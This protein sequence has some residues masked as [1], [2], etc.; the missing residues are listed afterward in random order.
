MR[1]NQFEM[2]AAL[3][4][5][6]SL[7]EASEKL[8]ISQ[9]SI[10]KAIRELEDEVGY[11]IIKRTKN[12]VEFTEQGQQVLLYSKEIL[13][14]VNKIRRL[15]NIVDEDLTGIVSFGVAKMWGAEIFQKVFIRLKT[16]Y[17][18]ILLHYYE[19]YSSDIIA[20]VE[21]RQL[22]LGIIMMYSTDQEIFQKTIE[23]SG[24]QYELLFIDE[25]KLY[26]GIKHELHKQGRALSMAQV[27][28][29]P[30][31]TGGNIMVADCSKKLLRSYGYKS[32]IE[33][34]N[35]QQLLLQYLTAQQAFTSMPERIYAENIEYQKVLKE[36][37]VQDLDWNC[38][39]GFVYQN[40]EWSSVE[41]V[42]MSRLKEKLQRG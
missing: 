1:L 18:N 23:T 24:L 26:A 17:P 32:E 8:Y 7:S 31:V 39:V 29:Y 38:Q 33:I 27:V 4:V 21:N 2:I 11:P 30:Y 20:K 41:K 12:G 3:E 40:R 28:K 10:S 35:N 22:D 6:A 5:C 9:P 36:V 14:C 25:V 37:F 15:Q 42:M 16:Q 34:I 19:G 13:E